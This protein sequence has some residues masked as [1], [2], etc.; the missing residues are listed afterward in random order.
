MLGDLEAI[1]KDQGYNCV[2]TDG[3]FRT[4]KHLD[5]SRLLTIRDGG[6][7]PMYTKYVNKAATHLRS[8]LDPGG[9]HARNDT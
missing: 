9:E 7:K 1:L 2:G 3:K 6:E 4:W 5:F 8:V